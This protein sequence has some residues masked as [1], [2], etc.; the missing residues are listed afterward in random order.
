MPKPE[1]AINNIQRWG[2]MADKFMETLQKQ[3]EH[4]AP[5]SHQV[6]VICFT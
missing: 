2:E 4:C 3:V 5:A 6:Q 1:R